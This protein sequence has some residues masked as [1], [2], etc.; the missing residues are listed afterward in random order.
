MLPEQ[1]L[2]D[3]GAVTVTLLWGSQRMLALSG[4]NWLSLGDE[5]PMNYAQGCLARRLHR[6]EERLYGRMGAV[7][8]VSVM[9]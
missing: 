6:V 3:S 1:T 4:C 5:F 7:S 2:K 8:N 9:C